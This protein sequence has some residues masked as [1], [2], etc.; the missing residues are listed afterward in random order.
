MTGR[1]AILQ[2]IKGCYASLW[3]PHAL[4]YRRKMGLADEAVACAVLIC[5]MII[6]P[7][8]LPPIAAG[9]AFS[10]DPRTGQRDR[11]CTIC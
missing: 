11:V 1:Q 3:T 8:H 5:A 6:G 4:A 2:A 7:G 9:V 10:C